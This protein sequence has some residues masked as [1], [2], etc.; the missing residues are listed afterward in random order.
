MRFLGKTIT[1]ELAAVAVMVLAPLATSQ[2]RDGVPARIE[3]SLYHGTGPFFE[4]QVR[5]ILKAR[6]L[7]C[8][9]EGPKVKGGLRLD[10]R[11]AVL[12]GGDLGPAVSLSEPKESRLLQA[13]RYEEIEMPPAGKLP[14][15]EIDVLTRWV[16]EGVPWSA[17]PAAAAII[18]HA[19]Q[20]ARRERKPKPAA[21]TWSFRPVVRPPVPAVKN[22]GL[23]PQP[24]RCVPP[25]P[26]R[27]GR[28]A[29][30]ARGR[31][32]DLDPAAQVRPDRPAADPRRGRRLRRRSGRRR[33][34]APGRPAA[35]IAALWREMGP[36]L[37][38]PGPLRRDQRLRARLGQAVRLAVPRLRDRRLQPR[39]AVRPVHPRT[40]GRRRGRSRPRPRR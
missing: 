10:S 40:T 5:P 2:A 32:R 9:G 28:L 36:A 27:G 29:A 25:G 31:S 33:L 22:R 7:K 35:R 8:H 30:G 38:R 37:A 20:G 12:R 19:G 4:T 26:A 11:E 34:R 39:Q 23:V 18:D 14:A 16:K 24:D 17:V 15:G 13:I 1:C 3:R 6:C 21:N